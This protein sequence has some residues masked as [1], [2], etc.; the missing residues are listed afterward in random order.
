LIAVTRLQFL[1]DG[2]HLFEQATELCELII[3]QGFVL[4]QRNFLEAL[5]ELLGR[6]IPKVDSCHTD[7]GPYAKDFRTLMGA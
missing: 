4:R 2:T 6:E 1:Q 3:Q 7:T 5:Y